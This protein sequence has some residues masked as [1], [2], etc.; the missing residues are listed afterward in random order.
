MDINAVR[1]DN[2]NPNPSPFAALLSGLIQGGAGQVSMQQQQ[3][4]K[5]QEDNAK[6]MSQIAVAMAQQNRL[7]TADPTGYNSQ[8]KPA[9]FEAG[10]FPLAGQQFKFTP[11]PVT[12]ENL[13]T[14]YEAQLLKEKLDNPDAAWAD[15]ASEGALGQL[16]TL[17]ALKSSQGDV[18]GAQAIMEQGLPLV[19]QGRDFFKKKSKGAKTQYSV[20]QVI[21]SGGKSYKVTG[22]DLNNDPDVVPI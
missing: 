5:Q 17:A 14:G 9:G 12:P 15:K 11:Q 22:G 1:Y 3:A 13:K 6:Y 18:K 16:A 2:P 21:T 20:G 19:Q 4:Q 8:G 7:S 10:S